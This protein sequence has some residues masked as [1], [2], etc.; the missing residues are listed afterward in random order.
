MEND[1]LEEASV[2]SETIVQ[3]ED[4]TQEVQGLEDSVEQKV[5]SI[6]D[7]LTEAQNAAATAAAESAEGYLET[8]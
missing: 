7:I 4:D 3:I 2:L 1:L 5:S 6:R 8:I